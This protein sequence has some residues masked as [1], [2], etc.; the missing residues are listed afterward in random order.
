MNRFHEKVRHI[1]HSVEKGKN[2]SHQKIFRQINSLVIPLVKPL[3]SRN[4]CQKCVIVYFRNF[5]TVAY[6]QPISIS[7]IIR[8]IEIL[9]FLF[10]LYKVWKLRKFTISISQCGKLLQNAITFLTEKSAFFPSNQSYAYEL[11]SRNFFKRFIVLFHTMDFLAKTLWNQCIHYWIALFDVSRNICQ[12]KMNYSV[13]MKLKSR[14]KFCK[15][16]ISLNLVISFVISKPKIIKSGICF[17]KQFIALLTKRIKCNCNR[18][19]IILQLWRI[20]RWARRCKWI[21]FGSIITIYGSWV[22][23]PLWW[24]LI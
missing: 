5:H 15:G 24:F 11:V 9:H 17:L 16:C 6:V 20:W 18:N 14:K 7:W 21:S 23:Q 3:L 19:F 2:Y 22:E 4:F 12:V 1:E 10:L 8:A 13:I